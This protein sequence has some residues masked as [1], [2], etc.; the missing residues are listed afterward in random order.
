M[1]FINLIIKQI[2]NFVDLLEIGL[3]I[4]IFFLDKF[5]KCINLIAIFGETCST[6][7]KFYNLFKLLKT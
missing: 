2:L 7:I 1:I 4:L 3:I 5:I 6:K